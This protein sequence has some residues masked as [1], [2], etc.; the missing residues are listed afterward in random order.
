MAILKINS[1]AVTPITKESYN[2]TIDYTVFWEPGDSGTTFQTY[3]D[4]VGMDGA[5]IDIHSDLLGQS[6]STK[7]ISQR[8]EDSYFND[9]VNNHGVHRTRLNENENDFWK[10]TEQLR[11]RGA[12]V[13]L[14]K[15]STVRDEYDFSI[16][17][18]R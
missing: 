8:N 4:F 11:V 1:A 9:V 14:E 16:P 13:R 18:V 10:F 2:F 7:F 12:L 17:N 6:L 3:F 15:G 5:R